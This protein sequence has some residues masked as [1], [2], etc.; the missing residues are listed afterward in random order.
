VEDSPQR[1]DSREVVGGHAERPCTAELPR[2][3]VEEEDLLRGEVEGRGHVAESLDVRLGVSDVG[4]VEHPIEVR[5]DAAVAKLLGDGVGAVRED[6][7]DRPVVT[8]SISGAE[9]AMRAIA[10]SASPCRASRVG[11]WSK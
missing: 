2:R 11:S 10:P 1:G 8:S 7:A 5:V 6:G 4:G 9:K 3:I